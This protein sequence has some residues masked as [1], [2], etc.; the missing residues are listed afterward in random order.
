MSHDTTGPHATNVL[1]TS[2]RVVTSRC[3]EEHDIEHEPRALCDRDEARKSLTFETKHHGNHHSNH[4]GL[5]PGTR[6]P[7]LSRAEDRILRRLEAEDNNKGRVTAS[8]QLWW[9]HSFQGWQYHTTLSTAIT[10]LPR[11]PVS[12]AT[13]VKPL[14]TAR[15]RGPAQ[16]VLI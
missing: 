1:F 14:P 7:F 2:L 4:I 10:R 16:S 3:H 13:S 8:T 12:W 11:P 9:D 5:M 6:S 15:W